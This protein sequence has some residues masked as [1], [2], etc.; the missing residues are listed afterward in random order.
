MLPPDRLLAVVFTTALGAARALPVVWMVAPLGGPR[1]PAA[2]RVGFA[3]LLALVASPVLA[4]SAGADR[5]ADVSALRFALMVAREV[6]IGLCLAL[7]ASAVFRAAEIAGRLADSLRGANVAEILD[8][9]SEERASPLG[10]LYLLLATLVFLQIGGVP[11]VVDALVGSY[12]ALPI[13][14]GLGEVSARRAAFV[15]AIIA[16]KLVAAGVALAAPV[17]VAL[18]LTDLAL[19]LIA[20]AAPSVPVYF[21]GLPIK[22]LL[23]IG[24]V[25]LGLGALEAAIAGNAATWLQMLRQTTDAF[26]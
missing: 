21:V 17:I 24:I 26:R 11:R 15:V 1:L 13:A 9:T 2:V 12:E 3:L 10:V 18:W 22:G 5:L 20:R 4:A 16:A 8:P 25:L 23:A 14:G 7:V 19:G 6:V